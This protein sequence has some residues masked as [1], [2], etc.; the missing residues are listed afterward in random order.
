[1]H[2]TELRHMPGFASDVDGVMSRQVSVE[3]HPRLKRFPQRSG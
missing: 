3:Y 1:M 2:T